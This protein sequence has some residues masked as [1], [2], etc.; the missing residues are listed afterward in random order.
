MNGEL[1]TEWM[2]ALSS[3]W[4]IPGLSLISK[5]TR[6]LVSRKTSIN[7]YKIWEMCLQRV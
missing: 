2:V 4:S 5:L 1:V 7:E 3:S 6:D